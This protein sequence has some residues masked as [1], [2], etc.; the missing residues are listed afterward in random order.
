MLVSSLW[1]RGLVFT[2]LVPCVIGGYLPY[3]FRGGTSARGGLWSIGWIFVALGAVI[4][5]L[6]LF[7]FL[8]SGGT[9][10]VFFTRPLR[11]VLGEEPPKL[12][13]QGLYRFSRNPMYVG[14]LLAVFGQAL[15][16][17]SAAVARY[18]VIV[19]LIFHLVV[20]VLEEPHLRKE[21]GASYEEY[22][23]QVPRWLGWP[24]LKSRVSA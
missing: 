20:V 3:L 18:G 4:Y 21:R 17:M 1:I 12:V 24:R 6:C 7:S 15:I 8:A 19:W 13:R 2:L 14:V 9:P 5:G 16:F 22:C 10:A 11:F 23:R